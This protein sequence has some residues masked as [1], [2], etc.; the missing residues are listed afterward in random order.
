MGEFAGETIC[1]YGEKFMQGMLLDL[2]FPDAA[3][4]P[5]PHKNARREY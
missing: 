4:I 2:Q 1:Y 5:W 3:K